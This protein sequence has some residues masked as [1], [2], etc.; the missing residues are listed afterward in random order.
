MYNI[1]LI[2]IFWKGALVSGNSLA[3]NWSVSGILAYYLV[4]AIISTLVVSHIEE[5]VSRDDIHMGNMV[6]YLIRPFPYF[7]NK[8]FEELP[9]RVNQSLYG[10]I[11]LVSVSIIFK[12]KLPFQPDPL[13]L[14]G[15]CVS[16]IL[17][18][19]ISFVMKMNIGLSAFW[20]KDTNAIEQMENILRLIFGGGIMPII[21]FPSLFQK[22]AY[23]LPFASITYYP[24]MLFLNS[25]YT[26]L[27]TALGTQLMWLIF[28]IVLNRVLW[29]IGIKQFTGAGQ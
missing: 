12:I 25:F 22:I 10:V 21:L 28:L 9:Y 18:F 24:S 7:W 4:T 1:V 19:F 23:L 15:A 5:N 8:F 29:N 26:P 17:G 3:K 11:I 6:R 27:W 20:L 13:I 16:T 2:L 14:F